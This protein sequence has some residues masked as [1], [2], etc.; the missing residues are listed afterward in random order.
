MTIIKSLTWSQLTGLI[1]CSCLCGQGGTMSTRASSEENH[2]FEPFDCLTAGEPYRRWRR[3]LLGYCARKVDD[4]G[5][6]WA[7][8]LLDIDQGGNDPLMSTAALIARHEAVV[9]EICRE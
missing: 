4:T 3:A 7:D 5:S 9:E 1:V 6:S 2:L 8:C